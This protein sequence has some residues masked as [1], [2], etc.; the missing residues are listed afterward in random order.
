MQKKSN[1]EKGTN[2]EKKVVQNINSGALW[3]NKGDLKTEDYCIEC[4][5]TEKKG[6]RITTNILKKIWEEA[7]ESNKLPLMIVGI[8]DENSTWNLQIQINKE[9]I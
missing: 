8:K 9:T 6:Y 3:F 5:F 7:L 1:K 2:F 4:K